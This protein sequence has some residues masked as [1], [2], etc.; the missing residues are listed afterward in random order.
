MS[1]TK[2][3]LA[4]ARSDILMYY[5]GTLQNMNKTCQQE[6]AKFDKPYYVHRGRAFRSAEPMGVAQGGSLQASQFL[7][8]PART[9]LSN[10]L[11]W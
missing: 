11:T 2:T 3:L 8:E 6:N 7:A 9:H 5:V 1:D 10:H 4:D